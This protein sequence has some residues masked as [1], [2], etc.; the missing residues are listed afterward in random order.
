MRR[1]WLGIVGAVVCLSL[2]LAVVGCNTSTTPDKKM[3]DNKM[4][5]NKMT[6]SK[7]TNDKMADNKTDKK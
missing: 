5:D 1:V 2:G 6:D 4:T 3:D 7:M